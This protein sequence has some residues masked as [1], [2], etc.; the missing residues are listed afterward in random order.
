MIFV[1]IALFATASAYQ[2][3]R[4]NIRLVKQLFDDEEQMS[5]S[6]FAVG[7]TLRATTGVNIR[8][9][10]CTNYQIVGGLAPGQTVSFSGGVQAGCGYTWYS[11]NK[12]WIAA[13]F[14]TSVTPTGGGSCRTGIYPLFKQCN[15][16]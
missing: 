4:W 13:E 3:D 12:G 10:P 6:F 7:T 11:A 9:G 1:V 14:L 15:P 16:A 5:E 8:S 2:P